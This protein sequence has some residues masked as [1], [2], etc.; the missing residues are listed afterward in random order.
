VTDEA[1]LSNPRVVAVVLTWNRMKLLTEPL[2]RL[3]ARPRPPDVRFV[4]DNASTDGSHDESRGQFHDVDLVTLTGNTGNDHFEFTARI[5]RQRKG[6]YLPKAIVVHKTAGLATTLVDP[7]EWV[8]NEV[9]NTIGV[10]SAG[11]ACAPA[12]AGYDL[13]P[14]W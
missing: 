14:H 8:H 13:E 2:T 11:E 1:I 10:L 7:G 9:R 12:E 6:I 4:V 3:G 5:L